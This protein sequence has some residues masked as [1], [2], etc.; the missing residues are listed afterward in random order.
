MNPFT[1]SF[2]KGFTPPIPTFPVP[3]KLREFPFKLAVLFPVSEPFVL[4][5]LTEDEAEAEPALIHLV[6]SK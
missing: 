4:Y 2:A 6:P 5:K 1:F 3:E